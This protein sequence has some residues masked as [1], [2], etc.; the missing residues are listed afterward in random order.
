MGSTVEGRD[1]NLLTIGNQVESDL[2]IWVIARQHPGETMAEWFIEGLLA[3]LLDPQDPTAR[4]L[5]D[6]A[7][8]YVVPNM[9]PDGSALGNLRTNAAGAN[10]NRE[11]LSPSEERSPEVFYV[12]EKMRETGVDLFLDIHGD[13]GLPYIFVA[14]TEGVP[15]YG[16]RIAALESRFKAAFAAASPDFQDEHWVGNTFDCLAYTLEMPFKD[17]HNLPDDDFGW[18][19]QRSLRLGEAVLSAI[20][21]VLPELRP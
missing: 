12:R 17:N 14:G 16:P 20:L 8:F 13:E 7:T 11:W 4:A 9:N 19:G 3:R 15:G 18:N 6:S 1:I 5:L 21:N 10:L 2:K